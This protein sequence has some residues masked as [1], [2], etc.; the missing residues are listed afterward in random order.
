ML[1]NTRLTLTLPVV[2]LERAKEF[3]TTKLGLSL[4]EHQMPGGVVLTTSVGNYVFLYERGAT[5]AD[6]TVASFDVDDVEA[7]V[8]ELSSKGVEFEEYELPGAKD[9]GNHVYEMGEYKSAW[10]KDTEGNILAIG[11]KMN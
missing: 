7:E 9:I 6:H 4:D 2:D 1:G 11:S 5:K 8:A 10:F 3:Y